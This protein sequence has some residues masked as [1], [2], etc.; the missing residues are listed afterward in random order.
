M[1]ISKDSLAHSIES[2]TASRPPATD[3]LTYLT[4]VESHL[5]P[6]ILPTLN[7]V[8]QDVDLTQNIGWDLVHSLINIPGGET[9]LK[10]IAKLGNPREVILQVTEALRQL[11][12][13]ETIEDAEE[14]VKKDDSEKAE[15]KPSDGSHQDSPTELDK[16]CILVSLLATL[17]PRIKTKFPSRFLST[18]LMAI[19]SS[20]R[21]SNQ[22]TYAVIAFGHAL[23]GQKRPILPTRKSSLSMHNLAI[24]TPSEK[25]ESAPDP[26]A[27][28]EDP[29]EEGIQQ[30][31][32][33]S[34]VTHV[35]QLYI[36]E[37]PLQWAARLQ[38]HYA[39][40]KI[41]PSRKSFSEKYREDPIL[42]EREVVVGQIVVSM[43]FYSE[44]AFAHIRRPLLAILI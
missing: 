13:D 21:P 41:V 22:A 16:F 2:V 5:S 12:L 26:E 29:L 33:Q 20:Y 4:I 31:L 38:E 40:S 3:Y 37:N 36:S 14:D 34:F 35:L 39:P 7:D 15:D 30:K 23:S 43:L 10:T 8:L 6:E 19:L 9:C 11:N 24:S 32:L 17:H 42:Q 28:A 1:A 27:T 18:S 25:N 44:W